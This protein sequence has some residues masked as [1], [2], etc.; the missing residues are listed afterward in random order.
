MD[1]INK[2]KELDFNNLTRKQKDAL[3]SFNGL[4]ISQTYQIEID[5][6]NKVNDRFWFL[7]LDDFVIK[8]DF[9]SH[10]Q[11]SDVSLT[12]PN[13]FFCFGDMLESQFRETLEENFTAKEMEFLDFI[14]RDKET[15][16]FN[17]KK[18]HFLKDENNDFY[19]NVP[20]I[21]DYYK[22]ENYDFKFFN[23]EKFDFKPF[24]EDLE[25]ANID[26]KELQIKVNRFYSI[27]TSFM[28]GY[29]ISAFRFAINKR[30][31][32]ETLKFI[33]RVQDTI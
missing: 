29:S 5:F 18:W 13:Y 20:I 4:N 28:V 27:Y 9:Q 11:N 24:H 6:I 10:L 15:E 17:L 2:T 33:Q 23:G 26:P 1:T 21:L 25:K 31:Y 22:K 32:L 3:N 19:V 8:W 14:F 12:I 30:F 7:D 16:D